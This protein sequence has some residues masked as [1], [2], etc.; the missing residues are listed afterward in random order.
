MRPSDLRRHSPIRLVRAAIEVGLTPEKLFHWQALQDGM[1]QASIAE[2]LGITQ[3]AVSKRE[4]VL[5]SA[6]RRHL[7]RDRRPCLPRAPRGPAQ[8][9]QAGRRRNKRP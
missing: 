5:R 1:T 4:R 8:V 9:V 6:N 3:G 2:K 7:G